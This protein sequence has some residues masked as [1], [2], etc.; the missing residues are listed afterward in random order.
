LLKRLELKGALVTIDAI[1]TQVEIAKIIVNGGG[2]YLLA[3]KDNW[4]AFRAEVETFFAD[5]TNATAFQTFDTTDADHG[6]LEQR[7]H[8][9]CQEVDWLLSERRFPK[10]RPFP[11]MA[12][13]A[14]VQTATERAGKV[15]REKRYYISPSSSTQTYSPMRSEPIGA[16]R[17]VCIGSSTSSSTTTSRG[18]EP[19]SGR[20]IWPS[21]STSP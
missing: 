7:H 2:D 20:R 11:R 5:D 17:T 21:S 10:E 15:E 6:R 3:L 4:P 13:I 9:V 16:S 19:A 12:M 8:V 1:G 18:C 14:M